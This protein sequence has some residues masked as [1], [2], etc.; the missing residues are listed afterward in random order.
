ME[1][2]AELFRSVLT[3][4]LGGLAGNLSG[5]LTGASAQDL[6][7]LGEVRTEV[8]AAVDETNAVVARLTSFVKQLAEAGLYPAVPKAV[9]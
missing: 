9:K 8:P 6:R 3:F 2:S 7:T 5:F 1:F 4:K